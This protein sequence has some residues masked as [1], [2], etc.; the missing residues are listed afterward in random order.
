MSALAI[1]LIAFGVLITVTRGPFIYAPEKT[2]ARTLRLFN[3]DKK[4]RTLGVVFAVTGAALV[5]AADGAIG[6]W[7]VAVYLFG[8]LALMISL[9]LMIPFPGRMQ[10]LAT[11]IWNGFSQTTLRL[12][13]L[14]STVFGAWL[15]YVG[16]T[17]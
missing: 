15:I 2:R 12:I 6:G 10:P 4:M 16:F 8:I 11:R 13:G 14:T 5:W 1:A 9:L 3:T 7:A 17:L